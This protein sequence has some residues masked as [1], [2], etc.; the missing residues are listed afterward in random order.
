MARTKSEY[1][2]QRKVQEKAETWEDVQ[3]V[4]VTDTAS[5]KKWLE[6]GG[7][8]GETYR[9]VAIRAV[10]TLNIETLRKVTFE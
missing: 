3:A 5:G 6:H 4:D 10:L 2:I 1:V 7:Q 8:E 9:I